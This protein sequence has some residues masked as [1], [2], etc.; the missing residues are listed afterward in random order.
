MLIDWQNQHSKNGY[1]LV[2]IAIIKNNNNNK[3]WQGC[4]EKSTLILLVE[5]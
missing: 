1:T 2:R 5:M 4:G 3:R